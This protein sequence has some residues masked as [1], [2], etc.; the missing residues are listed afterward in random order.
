MDHTK[1]AEA[2]LKWV[3]LK[4]PGISERLNI[5]YKLYPFSQSPD[6]HALMVGLSVEH[7]SSNYNVQRSVEPRVRAC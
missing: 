3:R 6:E 2:I 7:I 1:Y 4:T 5:E